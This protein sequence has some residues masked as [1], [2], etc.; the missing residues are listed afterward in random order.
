MYATENADLMA[1]PILQKKMRHKDIATT[2]RYINMAHK[3]KR[4][5]DDVFIPETGRACH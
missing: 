1:V 5:T 4:A 3:M 2:M